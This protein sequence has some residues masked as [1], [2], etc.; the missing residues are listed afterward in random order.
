MIIFHK[1]VTCSSGKPERLSEGRYNV[2]DFHSTWNVQISR[3]LSIRYCVVLLQRDCRGHCWIAYVIWVHYLLC[4]IFISLF[5]NAKASRNLGCVS[6][7]AE[8]VGF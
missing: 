6:N 3:E 5:W 8:A 7:P 1:T 4:C 2:Y